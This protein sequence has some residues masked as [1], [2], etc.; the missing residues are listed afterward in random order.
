MNMIPEKAQLALSEPFGE[1]E[2][3]TR[4]EIWCE[5]CAADNCLAHAEGVCVECGERGTEAHDHVTY[6]PID[7]LKQRFNRVDPGWTWEP[8][9]IA[10]NGTPVIVRDGNF[11]VFWVA[12]TIGGIT[13]KGVGFASVRSGGV[14]GPAGLRSQAIANAARDFGC[15]VIPREPS[16]RECQPLVGATRT[17]HNQPEPE[18]ASISHTQAAK[19]AAIHAGLT[20]KQVKAWG[21]QHYPDVLMGRLAGTCLLSLATRSG[22]S[23]DVVAAMI[24]NNDTPPN[25][26]EE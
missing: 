21:K 24:Q 4:S 10:D 1:D 25:D 2:T 23:L 13:H 20:A 12:L 9:A 3:A 18:T 11:N 17:T 14:F 22:L 19:Q 15:G 26:E 5:S 8:L 7:S 6:V 16:R